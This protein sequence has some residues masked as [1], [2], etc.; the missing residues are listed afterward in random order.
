MERTSR[1]ESGRAVI[2]LVA[3][4][5]ASL[6]GQA[7]RSAD[8]LPVVGAEVCPDPRSAPTL[9]LID[10]LHLEEDDAVFL[11]SPAVRFAVGDDGA[12]YIP[13]RGN[14]RLLRFHPD[15]K[16]SKV[17]SRQGTGPGEFQGISFVT[18][19]TGGT[20]WQNDY[21][22]RRISIFDTSGTHRGDLRYRG[23]L[24]SLREIEATVWAGLADGAT[25]WVVAQVPAS[26]DADS[27]LV[28]NRTAKPAEYSKYPLL[29]HM[30]MAS[31]L[32]D[33]D[34]HIVVFGGVEYLVRFMSDGRP[35]DTVW[36]PVCRRQGS[37]EEALL[38]GFSR[39]PR[40]PEEAA[41]AE[42]FQGSISGLM[43]AWRMDDGSILIW[44]QDPFRDED[45]IIRS[46]AY[47][48]VLTSDLQRA[49]VDAEVFAPASG[50]AILEFQGGR[51]YLLDQVVGS[52]QPVPAV[53]TIVRRFR[54]DTSSC[55]WIEP[56][57]APAYA[58]GRG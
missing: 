44:Y 19:V 10:S 15:G 55:R 17:F 34:G 7:C 36:I 12:I 2:P 22:Q 56:R 42:R 14:N 25:D 38:A 21:L 53:R 39:V 26:M 27:L 32:P 31:V 43:N 45:G 33:P 50:R 28:P 52:E 47:L 37:P 41:Q 11:A 18:M 29:E 49:C 3:V 13:D 58:R 40:T 6:G 24:Y 9:V 4:A 51:L 1:R 48:S 57:T 23:T 35:A 54:V 30:A 8:R 46:R 20:I 5:I 16:V